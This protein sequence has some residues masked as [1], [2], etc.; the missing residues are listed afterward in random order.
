MH[1]C[2]VLT[3]CVLLCYS[4]V[5]TALML[6][7]SGFAHS[8]VIAPLTTLALGFGALFVSLRVP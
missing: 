6:L 8:V 4:R 2:G 1:I 5:V 7:P 3:I